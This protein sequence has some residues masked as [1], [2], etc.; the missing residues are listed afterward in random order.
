MT[1]EAR[2]IDKAT[3]NFQCRLVNALPVGLTDV[4]VT[5]ESGWVAKLHS[6]G[7]QS[8]SIYHP[9]TLAFIERIYGWTGVSGDVLLGC[10]RELGAA[11]PAQSTV[12]NT[13]NER[14]HGQIL[15]RLVYDADALSL[16][17][18]DHIK[19]RPPACSFDLTCYGG[20]VYITGNEPADDSI[21]PILIANGG[22]A[23][24]FS[25]APAAAGMQRRDRIVLQPIVNAF[26]IIVAYEYALIS[27][28]EASETPIMPARP[29]GTL[30][31]AE[32]GTTSY[33]IVETT[34]FFWEGTTDNPNTTVYAPV[35]I[36]RGDYR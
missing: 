32:I 30:N 12:K 36:P 3:D 4:N 22:D 29:E 13:Y 33:P 10:K 7:Y 27:G 20:T 1:L 15:D 21:V 19:A 6:D 26:N 2:H 35:T 34:L 25:A 31:V 11:C 23:V 18:L 9:S 5:L 24:V 8:L 14:T 17:R 16:V 28:E